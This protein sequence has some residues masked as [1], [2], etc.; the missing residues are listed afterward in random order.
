MGRWSLDTAGLVSCSRHSAA[1]CGDYSQ[2]TH[3]SQQFPLHPAIFRP[4][5]PLCQVCSG[6]DSRILS[7]WEM[8]FFEC[9]QFRAVRWHVFAIG[10]PEP[11]SN[12]RLSVVNADSRQP[13]AKNS[14]E[15]S[16]GP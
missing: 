10:V 6:A 15:M 3:R 12:R 4:V 5:P 9:G 7:A 14:V 1:I 2:S 13:S 8:R 11:K 16:I